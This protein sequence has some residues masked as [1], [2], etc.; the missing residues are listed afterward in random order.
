MIAR[1]QSLRNACSTEELSFTVDAK[2]KLMSSGIESQVTALIAATLHVDETAVR[3]ETSIADEL[4]A[5]SLDFVTLI[6]A[7]ED[8]FQL[9]M[10]DEEA[11]EILTVAQLIEYVTFALATK[12]TATRRPDTGRW[13][14]LR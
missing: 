6:L 4:G 13:V 14:A 3:R 12:E 11:A 10:P 9:D 7:I 8:E 2:V 1:F 5:D